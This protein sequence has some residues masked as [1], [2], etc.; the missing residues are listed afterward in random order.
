[1]H[2]YYDCF[3]LPA[4]D[5]F[6]DGTFPLVFTE[7]GARQCINIT[8]IDDNV[9]ETNEDVSINLTTTNPSVTL[10]PKSVVL[11]IEDEDSEFNTV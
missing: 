4:D 5:D 6:I 3:F 1:M 8:I 9:Y 11:I 10:M 7:Q 2:Y